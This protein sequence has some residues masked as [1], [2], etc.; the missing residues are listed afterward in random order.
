MTQSSADSSYSDLL[1][2]VFTASILI[3]DDM[4]L[5]QKMIGQCLSRAGYTNLS[6]AS[7]G[8]EALKIIEKKCP[9]LVVLD[10]N[11][12]KV[13]GYEVCRTLRANPDYKNL[14]ILVQS[15][16]ET[17]K[18]RTEVFN[19]GGTDF[20][21][22]P[23]NQPELL[24]RVRMHL[25]NKFLISNLSAFHARVRSELDMAREMQQDILPSRPI[26]NNLED[27]YGVSIEAFYQASSELGGD[28]WGIWDLPNNHLG[29]YVLDV[30][31]H[32]VGAALN[33][34][35]AH[36]A[37]A[38]LDDYKLDPAVFLDH[39]NQK[40]VKD[41]PTGSFATMFYGV[42]NLDTHKMTFAGAGAPNP[43]IA[44]KSGECCR[45][46]S[47]G[48]P[49]GILKSATYENLTHQLKAGDLIFSYSDVLLEAV[50]KDGNFLGDEGLEK[51][52]KKIIRKTDHSAD[53]K[54]IR[55]LLDKFFS[56]QTE[57]QLDDDLTAVGIY[58]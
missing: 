9:D 51:L 33:T 19:V 17:A 43:L 5:M 1:G 44:S 28:L 30:S 54:V 16:A 46:D 20:V 10:L 24:A 56:T 29:F 48:L 2:D 12:P 14:P 8:D 22:K 27:K 34:F 35:R 47:S 18:E 21:S 36:S 13:S 45:I 42:V 11:M 39:L 50:G 58:L 37:M 38:M 25:E 4:V 49:I 41:F 53:K 6:Y 57:K 15:A 40:L 7:D 23:I 32:G 31:G 26:L 3:V 52:F 55:F